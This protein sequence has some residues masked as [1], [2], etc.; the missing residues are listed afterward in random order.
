MTPPCYLCGSPIGSTRD[1][2]LCQPL[3]ALEARVRM[4]MEAK[5][6]EHVARRA[7]MRSAARLFAAAPGERRIA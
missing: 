6:A 1:C 3:A 2:A 5:I 7:A 4:V